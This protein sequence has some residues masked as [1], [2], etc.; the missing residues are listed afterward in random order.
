MTAQILEIAG[1]KLAVLPIADY[2]R[3]VE[4]AED[5]EDILAADEIQR[6]LD[7]G[8]EEYIPAKIVDR[9]IVGESPLKVWRQ[10]REMSG[11]QLA[12]EVGTTH[13]SISRIEN[14]SQNPTAAMWRKLANA[15]KVDVD[16]IIPDA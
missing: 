3:L 13:A 8:D 1:Q 5:R 14:G 9:L 7:C 12:K 6:R 4:L 10:Y 2:E 11:S 15:L 16:D